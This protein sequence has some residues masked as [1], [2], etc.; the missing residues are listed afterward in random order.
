LNQ[1]ANK[2]GTALEALDSERLKRDVEALSPDW[3][4]RC[5]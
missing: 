5:A 1:R 2:T 4:R 3:T